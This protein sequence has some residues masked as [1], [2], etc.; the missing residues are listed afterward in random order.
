MNRL[1]YLLALFF[2]A[3]LLLL[4]DLALAAGDKAEA[5]I[6]VADTRRVTSSFTIWILDTYNTN[7]FMLGIW[8]TVFTS[9][10]GG[11]LGFV[12]DFLM[13]RTGLDLTSRKI[14]EH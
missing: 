3:A 4:P 14:V 5:L 2:G 6:V 8:C 7:P 10:L 9:L 13:K 12:T 1:S 11:T